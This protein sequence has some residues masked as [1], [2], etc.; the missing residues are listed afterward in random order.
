[1]AGVEQFT[2][3]FVQ[4]LAAAQQ[5]NHEYFQSAINMGIGMT[6]LQVA[7][8]SGF[9]I[10]VW[11][12]DKVK[13]LWEPGVK[14]TAVA[15]QS[16][17]SSELETSPLQQ[18]NLDERF[19]EAITPEE[20]HNLQWAQLGGSPTTQTEVAQMA[21]QQPGTSSITTMV[22]P[23]QAGQ[24]PGTSSITTMVQQPQAVSELQQ[25][26]PVT[27]QKSRIEAGKQMIPVHDD[28]DYH[29]HDDHNDNHDPHNVALEH[30]S[31]GI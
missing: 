30:V 8:D 11:T 2:M 14:A 26:G 6:M 29:N 25:R 23:L 15:G 10:V 17:D 3:N 22:R 4:A 31:R 12:Y 16:R 18:Q 13:G 1:M 20:L 21:G 27:R 24:Q 7:T 19:A 5:Q 9:R 28:D